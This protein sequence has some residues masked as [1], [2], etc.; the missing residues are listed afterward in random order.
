MTAPDPQIR[1]NE[2]TDTQIVNEIVNDYSND[3]AH[4]RSH[5]FRAAREGKSINETMDM[6]FEEK[7][8]E[9][10][11]ASWR[12]QARAWVARFRQQQNEWRSER[13]LEQEGA[14]TGPPF[15][16]EQTKAETATPNL[17][18]EMEQCDAIRK[19]YLPAHV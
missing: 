9:A 15:E 19:K 2:Q 1:I 6:I 4:M 16:I 5:E 18:S 8:D 10:R 17:A 7:Q 3:Y 12:N 11:R 14:G 13:V